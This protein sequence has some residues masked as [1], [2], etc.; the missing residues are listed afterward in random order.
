[1]DKKVIF[2]SGLYDDVKEIKF[3][4]ELMYNGMD[5]S[6][7]NEYRVVDNLCIY[8]HYEFKESINTKL[9]ILRMELKIK[10][11]ILKSVLYDSDMILFSFSNM[12]IVFN[13]GKIFDVNKCSDREHAQMLGLLAIVMDSRMNYSL[14]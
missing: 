6:V 9:E 14:D 5:E 1:M 13:N 12:V 10:S 3:D 8:K 4:L 7:D 2:T 11:D